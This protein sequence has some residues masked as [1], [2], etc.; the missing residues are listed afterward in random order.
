MRALKSDFGPIAALVGLANPA[1]GHDTGGPGSIHG[2]ANS[3]DCSNLLNF[4]GPTQYC[5]R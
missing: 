1:L 2:H 5:N 4:T 3:I